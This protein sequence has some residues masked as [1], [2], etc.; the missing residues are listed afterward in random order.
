MTQDTLTKDIEVAREGAVL[1][2]AF[3][4]PQKKN[5]I[6]GAMYEALIEAFDAAERDPEIGALVMSGKGGVFTAGNDIG[7][8]LAVALHETGEFPA[9]RFVSKVAAFEKPLIAA[10]DGLAIGVGTTLCL[11]CDLV[12]ATPETRFQMPFVNLG[13]VPE[14]GSS[15]LAPQRFRARQGFRTAAA[16]RALRR[17]SGARARP[18]QR[19]P[20]SGRT[21]GAC[22]EQG[23]RARRQTPRRPA[24]DAAPHA[25]RSRGAESADGRRNARLLRRPQVPRG[26]CGVPGVSGRGKE[27]GV[28]A[29]IILTLHA[30]DKRSI[31]AAADLFVA[32][33]EANENYA[34]CIVSQC[35]MKS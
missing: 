19:D 15:L 6:T 10:I 25:R 22:D 14:A 35:R 27:V 24:R 1:S 9:W 8:F 31:I 3:A 30:A 4:R 29:K 34:E 21:H 5:A 11:H 16:C 2:A 23:S 17:R 32:S 7:D 28:D 18:H 12:Y 13:L 20:A 33:A 26:A